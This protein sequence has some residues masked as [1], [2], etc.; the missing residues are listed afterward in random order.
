MYRFL[1]PLQPNCICP[2]H[3]SGICRS[4][5]HLM[6]FPRPA[7]FGNQCSTGTQF[8]LFI[9][10]S[11]RRYSGKEKAAPGT[12]M[13]KGITKQ[14]YYLV[15]E[16]NDK[17]GGEEKV[18][19]GKGREKRRKRRKKRSVSKE[20]QRKQNNRSFPQYFPHG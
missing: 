16:I 6:G 17:Q 13:K 8:I 3:R 10:T 15:G 14:Y 12:N 20:R 9:P 2:W 19:E 7:R 1:G 4:L 18:R 11:S 5:K